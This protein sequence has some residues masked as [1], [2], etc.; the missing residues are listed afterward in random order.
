MTTRRKASPDEV[1]VTLAHP[2]SQVEHL[3]Y[4]GLDE[5]KEYGVGDEI[6]VNRNAA[7]S[8][9]SAGYAADVDPADNEAVADLLG[10]T[11]G[12]TPPSGPA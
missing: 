1:K 9:V 10:T 2:L 6:T 3:R 8:L 11:P 4:L 5:S 12:Q 7:A